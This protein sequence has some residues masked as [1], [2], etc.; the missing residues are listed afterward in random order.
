MKKIMALLL[1][2]VLVL[3]C[4][5]LAEEQ[6]GNSSYEI[7][8]GRRVVVKDEYALTATAF[9][10]ADTLGYYNSGSSGTGSADGYYQ[11]GVEAEYAMLYVNV[12]NLSAAPMDFLSNCDVRVEYGAFVYGGW[13]QQQRFSDSDMVN[14]DYGSTAC[15]FGV[16]DKADSFS[17]RP[18]ERG[19]YVFG[20]TLPNGVLKGSEDLT[21]IIQ[22]GETEISY[23]IGEKNESGSSAA[24]MSIGNY[25]GGF[26]IETSSERV[27]G[28]RSISVNGVCA[29][30]GDLKTAWNTYQSM[31]GE[32]IKLS[33]KDGRAY[34]VAGIRIANGYWK[35]QKVY[36][37]NSRVKTMSIYGD[38]NHIQTFHVEDGVDYQTYMFDT[39]AVCS[40]W[41]LY[42]E[43]GY[44]GSSYKDCC[45]TE[46]DLVGVNGQ[47]L[48]SEA[49]NDWGRAVQSLMEHVLYGGVL[50]KG[51]SG[52]EVLGLQLLLKDGFGVLDGA[53]DGDFGSGTQKAIDKLEAQM[54][55]ALGENAVK[56]HSGV[57]DEAYW[58]NMLA[59]MDYLK[60]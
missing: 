59:Y 29:I 37:T 27:N 52:F 9:S 4:G 40:E 54:Q 18:N 20:C 6:F 35:S 15:D 49:I 58:T 12:D 42:I 14:S 45:I 22:L 1:A 48:S 50:A 55:E 51:D 57:V 30:D 31:S 47:S 21:M 44:A 60:Q 16:I 23:R 11:S 10:F 28:N 3:A 2:A 34:E 8:I 19:R 7:Q 17:I 13:T 41:M 56:M 36:R 53:I 32:W 39:P 43:D 5:G 33:T 46:L 26:D 25:C 24:A 38:G